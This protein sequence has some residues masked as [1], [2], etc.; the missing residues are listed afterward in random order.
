[1]PK[2]NRLALLSRFCNVEQISYD[3]AA[4]KDRVRVNGNSEFPDVERERCAVDT[5]L[6]RKV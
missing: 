1:M 6:Q 5:V 4:Q 2:S 3:T